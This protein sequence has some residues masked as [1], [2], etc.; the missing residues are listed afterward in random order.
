MARAGRRTLI[1]LFVV[2]SA[3]CRPIA[4][5]AAPPILLFGGAG[6]SPNDV[7]AVE[8]ILER[9]KLAYRVSSSAELNRLTDAALRTYQL[10]IVPGGNFIDM[11]AS[12]TPATTARVRD[13]VQNGVNFLGICAG[14]FLAGNGAEYYNSFNLT[15][16]VRFGF[17][18]AERQGVRKAI[19]V[20]TGT[21]GDPIEHY[22]EDGPE[23]SGWGAVVGKYPD[24]TPAFAEGALGEGRVILAGVHPEAP[25]SWWRGMDAHTSANAANAYAGLLVRAALHGEALPHF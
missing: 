17:Y 4:E 23:L 9:E 12:L 18:A 6:T 2:C 13:A 19:V 1:L 3:A 7:G 24:G 16:G 5:R 11:A 25:D 14:A 20:V 10:V 15:S 21:A 8:R 22:W